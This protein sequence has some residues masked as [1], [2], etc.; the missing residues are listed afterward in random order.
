[1]SAYIVIVLAVLSR[2]L[3]HAFGAVGMGFTA[4]GGSLLFFGA[5]RSRWQIVPAVLALMATDIYL[6]KYVYGLQFEAK[7]Y[8]L[9]WAWY[10]GVCLFANA[11]LNK[12]ETALRVGGSV[13][14]S[15]TSFF[16]LSNLAVWATS[17]MYTHSLG[18]L[19]ACYGAALPFYR[20]DLVSTGLVVGVL[21]GLP[22][23]ARKMS[24]AFEH[25]SN[26]TPA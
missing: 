10:A 13:L 2:V 16:V 4:V 17:G 26:S 8:L 5:R 23:L 15:A 11:V 9:T 22:A 18:G 25:S 24:A 12:K 20:N 6:T 1:M 14:V 21:F 19:M 3:P 7:H